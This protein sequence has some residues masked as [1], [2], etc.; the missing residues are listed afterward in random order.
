MFHNF[1]STDSETVMIDA[2]TQ[3]IEVRC[4][5]CGVIAPEWQTGAPYFISVSHGV[6]GVW[7]D[8]AR[9]EGDAHH[10]TATGGE[11][12]PIRCEWCGLEVGGGTAPD[13]VDWDCHGQE[14]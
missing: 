11:D 1:T 5:Q 3:L 13:T 14:G 4:Y 10:F 12:D 6:L 7:C 2:D 8:G 9:H